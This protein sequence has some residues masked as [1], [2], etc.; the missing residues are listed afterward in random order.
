[1]TQRR[2][3][4]SPTATLVVNTTNVDSFKN[5]DMFCNDGDYYFYLFLASRSKYIK[6]C[7]LYSHG[8]D[9][10]HCSTTQIS[11]LIILVYN[12]ESAGQDMDWLRQAQYIVIGWFHMYYSRFVNRSKRLTT[13]MI[14]STISLYTTFTLHDGALYAC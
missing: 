11:C 6:Q 3:G 5:R 7:S 2:N 1:M 9:I 10:I 4:N 14:E 8:R 12:T 13:F